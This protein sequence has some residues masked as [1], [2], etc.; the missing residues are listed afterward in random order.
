MENQINVVDQNTQQIGQNPAS[1]PVQIPEKP[2]FNF[3]MI[4]TL[5]SVTLLF[6][7]FG[8]NIF[9]AIN[10]ANPSGSNINLTQPPQSSGF[11]CVLDSDCVIGIQT[12][13]CCS[14][15]EAVNKNIIGSKDWELYELG[16]D[17]SSRQS[18]SCGGTVACKPCEL[19]QKPVCSNRQCKFQSTTNDDTDTLKQ[20]AAVSLKLELTTYEHDNRVFEPV[21]YTLTNNSSKAVYFLRGC[22]AV[23]PEVYKV[24]V[25]QKT[26]LQISALV[27]EALPQVNQIPPGG[28]IELG[29]NQQNLGKFVQDG[30]YQLAVEYSF[31]KAGDYSIGPKFEAVSDIFT[32]RQVTWDINKQKQICEVY[33]A[34]FHSNDF[35]YSKQDCLER[36]NK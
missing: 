12:T 25:G 30:Q 19:P 26:K 35:F 27:C 18:K 23:L 13:S 8:W 1:Q 10:K 17:Y 21:K 4:S 29:W 31:D 15:P 9:S 34:G 33:G 11:A 36:L 6:G 5:V 14:C 28:N 16:K 2:K 20:N 7:I 3:W 24:Q 32:I 22:A